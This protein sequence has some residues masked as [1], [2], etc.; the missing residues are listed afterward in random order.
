M[1]KDVNL[2]MQRMI[3]LINELQAYGISK[4]ASY[5]LEASYE[6]LKQA[7]R[8]NRCQDLED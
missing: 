6:S 2:I 5:S 1:D 7:V 8:R 3:E 4:D